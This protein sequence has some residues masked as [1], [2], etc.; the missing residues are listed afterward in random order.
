M[1]PQVGEA[2]TICF[3]TRVLVTH[4]IAYL[5]SVDKI[6]VLRDGII[7]EAGTYEELMA[8]DGAFADFLRNYI[9][10][11]ESDSE[12]SDQG[13]CLCCCCNLTN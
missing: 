11:K 7:S 10:E 4:S 9:S 8:H 1:S 3:Q 13:W 6:I 5:S 2:A 12:G